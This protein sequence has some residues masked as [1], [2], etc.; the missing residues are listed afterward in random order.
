MRE[1]LGALVRNS[2]RK[3]FARANFKR[4]GIAPKVPH[5]L[6]VKRVVSLNERCEYYRFRNFFTGKLVRILERGLSGFWVEFLNIA[7]RERLNQAA[8]WA[9]KK[10]YLINGKFDD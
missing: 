7:D 1:D 2:I 5:P 10:R 3:D 6:N 9:N 4:R 8:G